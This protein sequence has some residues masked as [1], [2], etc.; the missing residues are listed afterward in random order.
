MEILISVIVVLKDDPTYLR[1]G[2][3]ISKFASIN[4]VRANITQILGEAVSTKHLQFCI[5]KNNYIDYI[6]P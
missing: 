1:L 4:D 5:V 3:K 6:I 2:L